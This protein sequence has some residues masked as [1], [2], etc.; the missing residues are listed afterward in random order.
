VAL[1]IAGAKATLVAM[2]FMGLKYDNKIN[3]LAF[4][5]SIVFLIIFIGFTY[6]DTGFRGTF[7]DFSATP[8][9]EQERMFEQQRQRVEEIQSLV[10]QQ[11]LTLPPDAG[12]T[13]R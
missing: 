11:P 13:D 7:D 8:I 2:Y 9:D 3:A 4:V 12:M 5:L 6:L 1:A 10:E